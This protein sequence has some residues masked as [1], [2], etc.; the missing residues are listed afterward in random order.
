MAEVKPKVLEILGETWLEVRGHEGRCD[1]FDVRKIRG[2]ITNTYGRAVIVL[3]DP[4][5]RHPT[6]HD[7]EEVMEVLA[8]IKLPKPPVVVMADTHLGDFLKP[9]P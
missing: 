2:V 5:D 1:S 6:L 8:S 4:N 3:E 9:K 7:Y